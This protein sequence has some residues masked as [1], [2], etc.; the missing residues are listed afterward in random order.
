MKNRFSYQGGRLSAYLALGGI[1]GFFGAQIPWWLGLIAIGLAAILNFS[2]FLAPLR[3]WFWRKD[4]PPFFVGLGAAFLPCGWLHGWLALAVMAGGIWQ[5]ASVLFCL[6]LGSL[7]ALEGASFLLQRFLA[8]LQQRFPRLLP[9]LFILAALVPLLM[10]TQ[11]L[12]KA[13][14]HSKSVSCHETTN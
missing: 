5:G 14:S 4:L 9:V 7:P 13:P 6:W 12:A 11:V 2:R 8:P 1:L 10:R 3:N